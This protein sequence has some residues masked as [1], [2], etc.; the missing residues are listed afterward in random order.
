MNM[1]TSTNEQSSSIYIYGECKPQIL[2]KLRN[3]DAV[4]QCIACKSEGD[5]SSAARLLLHGF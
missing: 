1:S 5:I 3:T 2:D 4:K